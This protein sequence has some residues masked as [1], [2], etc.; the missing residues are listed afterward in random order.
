MED[1][2]VAPTISHHN[3]LSSSTLFYLSSEQI[4]KEIKYYKTTKS[5][6]IDQDYNIG[7]NNLI[8]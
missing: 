3:S 5:A 8:S 1:H 6:K 7:N 4:Q 2:N